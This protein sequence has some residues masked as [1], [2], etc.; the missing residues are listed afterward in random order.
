MIS[1]KPR[2]ARLRRLARKERLSSSTKP[3][4]HSWSGA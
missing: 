3:E 2:E 4:N 1:E